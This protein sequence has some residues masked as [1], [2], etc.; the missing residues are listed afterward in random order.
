TVPLIKAMGRGG[1]SV[2]INL[3]YNSQ[4]WRQD[5]GGTWNLGRDVGYGHGWKLQAGSLTAFYNGWYNLDHLV[6]TDSTGAEYRLDQ[7]NNGVWSSKESIYVWYD[8]PTATL[9]FRD[10]S[11]WRFGCWSG[12]TEEDT[13]TAY[14]TLIQDSN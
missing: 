2:P 13:G 8:L 7:N 11:F 10:G 9:H 14:P 6:F 1:W 12:G 4:N 3:S 5:P